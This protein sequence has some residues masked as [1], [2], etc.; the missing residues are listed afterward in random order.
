MQP[1]GHKESKG[2]GEGG[3]ER[4]RQKYID[5]EKGSSSGSHHKQFRILWHR[6]GIGGIVPNLSLEKVE[7]RGHQGRTSSST[8]HL[9]GRGEPEE[10]VTL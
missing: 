4:L 10:A 1:R 8:S 6:L 9:G 7:F 5:K 3:A 2:N